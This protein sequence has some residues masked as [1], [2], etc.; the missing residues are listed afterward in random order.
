VAVAAG[1]L[2]VGPA[3]AEPMGQLAQVMT[4]VK[5]PGV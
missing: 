1:A 2:V 3:H 5:I 4:A